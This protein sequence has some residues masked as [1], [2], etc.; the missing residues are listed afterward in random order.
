MTD[1]THD[2]RRRRPAAEHPA[3][4][5]SAEPRGY[6]VLTAES[7][8]EALELLRAEQPTSCPAGHLDARHGRLRG[9]PAD[10]RE[11]RHRLPAGRDDHGERHPAEG[12]GDRGRGRRLRHQTLRSGRAARQGQVAGSQSSAITTR[13]IVRRRAGSMEPSSWR[14][15]SKRRSPSSS[16]P[17]RLRRF[18]PPQMAEL[19]LDSGDE[20]FLESHRR[21]IVVV[22]C[23]LRQFTRVRRVQRARRGHGVLAEYHA[24]LGDLVFRF[25]G[26]LERF[27]GDGLMVVFNDPMPCD[28]AGLRA[29]RM[30]VAMRTRVRDLADVLVA[31][32]PRSRLRRRHRPGLRDARPDRVRG[33]LRLHRDRQRR[34]PRRSTVRSG[35]AVADPRHPAGAHRRART[36]SSARRPA[37]SSWTASAGRCGRST[38]RASTRP[39]RRT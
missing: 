19:V 6:R 36:S 20:S 15:A 3:A 8:E 9:V 35:A 31:S 13:S 39:R 7:G 34:Q 1:E 17:S 25:E 27:T 11:P 12:P 4:R 16:G 32:R 38:S 28:D 23:D 37:I 18:L 26:T 29:I 5:R 24:A 33:P 2:P 22:F 21:E 30:A 14:S 10:P